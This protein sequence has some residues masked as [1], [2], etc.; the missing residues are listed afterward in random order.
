MWALSLDPGRVLQHEH[1]L[2]PSA[3]RLTSDYGRDPDV[4]AL[5]NACDF[6]VMPVT[7]PDGYA[8][9]RAKGG[10]RM[11]RKTRAPNKDSCF[12]GT[13]ANRNFVSFVFRFYY[14]VF[15]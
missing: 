14:L 5:V 15:H 2:P 7:N 6:Y 3:P 8:F 1:S 13:D 4:T 9:T 11:W 12:L 10:N